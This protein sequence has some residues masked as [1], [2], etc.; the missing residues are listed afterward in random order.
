M[1][2]YI[3]RPGDSPSRIAQR[4]GMS[5]TE[6]MQWNPGLCSSPTQC[7]AIFPGQQLQVRQAGAQP[8]NPTSSAPTPITPPWMRLALGEQGVKEWSPG[9]NPRIQEYLRS[10]NL[11]GPDETSWCAAFLNWCLKTSGYP[12]R[13]S[14]RAA[15]WFDWGRAVVPVYGSIVL[16]QPLTAGA[17]G[18]V[19][20][21]HALVGEKVW[22]LSGN[23]G[24][25]VRISSYP[26]SKL[27]P[28]QPFRW[29][30]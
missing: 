1:A 25:Q 13:G 11:N 8:A 17:S 30:L 18:H 16:L 4:F 28:H 3:V 23:S 5:M 6:F 10:V 9:N 14:G 21:L 29:P 19:G 26:K 20:F 7:Q 24:N 12:H 2:T 27:Y 22:L 15:D